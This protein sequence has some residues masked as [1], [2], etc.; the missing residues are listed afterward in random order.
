MSADDFLLHGAI[1]EVLIKLL[2]DDAEWVLS[3]QRPGEPPGVVSTMQPEQIILAFEDQLK[4]LRRGYIS[5]VEWHETG[6][7]PS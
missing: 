6:G 4:A 5:P 7:K 3:Y 2:G 1:G